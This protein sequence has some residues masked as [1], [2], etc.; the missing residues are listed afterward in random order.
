[1]SIVNFDEQIKSDKRPSDVTFD[2][3]NRL[4][5]DGLSGVRKEDE[6][7]KIVVLEGKIFA[8]QV[9]LGK[10]TE[11]D[12]DSFE[13][14]I[15]GDYAFINQKYMKEALSRV[16]EQNTDAL[17]KQDSWNRQAQPVEGYSKAFRI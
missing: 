6:L 12:V 13:S 17:M 10:R 1:M 11:E 4:Y 16:R 5:D 8:N 7:A 9:S 3:I 15:P 2:L 14:L